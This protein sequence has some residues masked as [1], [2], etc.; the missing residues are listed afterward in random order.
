M[1]RC[2]TLALALPLSVA[3]AV[4]GCST[5]PGA[6]LPFVFPDAS[7]KP[8][9]GLVKDATPTDVHEFGGET[10]EGDS[11]VTPAD[12]EGSEAYQGVACSTDAACK[13][14]AGTPWCA[15][16]KKE[17]VECLLPLHCP[18]TGNCTNNKCLS[19]NCKAGS[20]ACSGG[21]LETC[22]ADGKGVSQE[23]C[24]DDKPFCHV[25]SCRACEPGKVY[26]GKPVSGS[27]K[28][29]LQCNA[30]GTGSTIKES[31][32]GGQVCVG[33]K[34]GVCVPGTKSCQGD[35]ALVCANDGNSHEMAQDCAANGW[36]CQGGLCVNPCDGDIKS[37]TNVGCD[38]WAVDLDNAIDA[39]GGNVYDAQNAQ[40]S[41]IVSNTSDSPATVTVIFGVDKTAPGA[42]FKAWTVQPKALQV[43]NLPDP[44]W[45]LPKGFQNQDGTNINNRVFRVQS[46]Q[47]IV[48]YQFNPLQNYG[49][50]SNDASLLLPGQSLGKTY[51]ILSR[52]QLGTKFRSYFT[53][54]ATMPG[55]TSVKFVVAAKTLAG[56][57]LPAMKIGEAKTVILKQGEVLN[58]ESDAVG[59]DLTGSYV[60]ADKLV[61]VF[62]GSEA[63]NSP[64][65]GNCVPKS[66]GL[67]KICASTSLNGSGGK[68]CT[69]D[70]D[71]DAACCADHLEEQLFPVAALGKTYVATRLFGRG[72]EQDAWRILA[73]E[74][75]TKVTLT[76][77]LQPPKVLAQGEW[78][79]IQTTADFLIDA[80]KPI[81]VG[82]YMA[83]SYATVTKEP[84]TCS[85]ESQCLSQHAF[86]GSCESAG[87]SK[88]CA[89]IGDPSLIIGVAAT[90]YLDDYLFLV[91]NK[92]KLNYINIVA[93]QGTVAT[94]DGQTLN[95]NQFKAIG[96]TGWTVA[97]LPIPDGAHHL[98][99]SKLAGLVV[100]GYD[101]DVSYGYPGGAGLATK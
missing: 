63:S 94:L 69:K 25:D 29:L 52:G 77:A 78:F 58:M 31:C 39:N 62:G 70:E 8:D 14:Q 88:V 68:A 73:A 67:G 22:N 20:V 48:A 15:K 60:E 87:F 95:P 11:T 64:T 59:A 9:V 86:L 98:T 83:S 30:E 17:C 34:C 56:P 3:L 13:G 16:F 51:W 100:Y 7:G 61:A 50:F 45:N 46:T 74:D 32:T 28:S 6:P 53:V 79:E 96:S 99:T 5:P 85:V 1:S 71:C 41:L 75:N 33:G 43:I 19:V 101:D 24:P 36:T 82:Q 42:K 40:Y 47:P 18:A 44:S 23:A 92:Y 49:V 84:A 80:D 72:K 27:S 97:R 55:D 21:F 66:S 26:C 4:L 81:L 91:P 10:V 57:G 12:S 54:V 2:L 65:F 37:N 93:Q 76:P 89:P 35:K 38:Y 90:Q